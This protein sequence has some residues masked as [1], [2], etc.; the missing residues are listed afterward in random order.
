MKFIKWGNVE[1][2]IECDDIE[3]VRL[4]ENILTDL[5]YTKKYCKKNNKYIILDKEPAFDKEDYYLKYNMKLKDN[6][7][8]NNDFL[9]AM[10]LIDD[11]VDT[12]NH[13]EETYK[14]D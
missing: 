10:Y 7:D 12:I 13:L 2:D 1:Y 8:N 11:L 3:P 6:A 4:I 9:F 5:V 14:E